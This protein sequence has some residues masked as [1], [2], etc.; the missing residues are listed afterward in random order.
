MENLHYDWKEVVAL[1]PKGY[2]EI[3]SEEKGLVFHGPIKKIEINKHDFVILTF[4]WVAQMPLPGIRGFGEWEKAPD[5]K[6]EQVFPNLIVPFVI[7]DTPEKGKRI[8]FAGLNIIYIDEI[9]GIDPA[10]VKG[11]KI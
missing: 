8:R 1:N 9:Q 10:Q 7:E 5:G 6:I 11:L 2:M 3:Q 4:E